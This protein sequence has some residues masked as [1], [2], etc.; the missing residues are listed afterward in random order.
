[1]TVICACETRNISGTWAATSIA[2]HCAGEAECLGQTRLGQGRID[3][4]IQILSALNNTSASESTV[5]FK[6]F[7]PGRKDLVRPRYLGYAYARA[8]RREDAERRAVEV[9]P[10]AY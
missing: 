8:S 1:M 3:E 5:I 2:A 6:E 4:A 9:A 10:N 7:I